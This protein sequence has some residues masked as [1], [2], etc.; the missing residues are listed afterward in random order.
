MRV[1]RIFNLTFC[2]L[3]AAQDFLELAGSVEAL[4]G[5][6]LEPWPFV[7][8]VCDFGLSVK[9]APAQKHVS[10]LRYGTPFYIAPETSASGHLSMAAD[11]YAFGAFS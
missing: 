9:T 1:E 2:A 4:A 8:K 11:S 7:A 6:V 10:N 3:A 5:T